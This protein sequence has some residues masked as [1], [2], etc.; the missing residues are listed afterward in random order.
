MGLYLDVALNVIGRSGY[1]H[2]IDEG[3]RKTRYMADRIAAS[4]E[5]ELLADPGMNILNYRYVP[6]PWRDKVRQNV[7]SQTDNI[8]INRFTER[9][10]KAQRQAGRTFVSRT[11]L[12]NTRYG[13]QASVVALRAVIANPL[14]MESDI[15]A[16]LADQTA[17]ASQLS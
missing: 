1:E 5:F 9:L 14:T 3:I 17:I 15:D 13:D 8:A 6:E 11:T 7:L 10:Q 16:V 2:L 4:A 12:H